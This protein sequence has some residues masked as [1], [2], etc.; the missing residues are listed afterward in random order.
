M[1]DA[2]PLEPA[3]SYRIGAVS[4]LTGVPPD[5]LRVWE[6]RYRVVV[7]VRS[8]SG[9][10]LYGTEDV[11]RLSLIKRLV[12]Q[13]DAIGTV[14]RLPLERLRER[15]RGTALDARPAAARPGR[16]AVLGPLLAERLRAEI[17]DTDALDVVGCFA[18]REAFLSAAPHVN[19]TLALLEYPTLHAEQVR[20][21]GQLIAHAGVERA[22]VVYA[23]ANRGTLERLDARRVMTRRGP[24]EAGDLRRWCLLATHAVPAPADATSDEIDLST[25][26]PMRRFSERDLAR[27]ALAT[28]ELRCECPRHL[29]ELVNALNAFATYSQECE[30]RNGEDAALHAYLHIATCQARARLEDALARLVTAEGLPLGDSDPAPASG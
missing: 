17:R 11:A 2:E 19:P 24:L 27:I 4:R 20:E 3:H 12:D 21:I 13:G 1:N 28:T 25:R 26:I 15:L 14:A 22:L 7:P 30:S 8:E 5:T 18:T 9:T 6:R 23:F 16:V 10:R 29:A